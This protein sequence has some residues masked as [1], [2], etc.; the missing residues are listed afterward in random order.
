[1]D[2]IRRYFLSPKLKTAI[3]LD[4]NFSWATASPGDLSRNQP[5]S[6]M[7]IQTHS[8]STYPYLHT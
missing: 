6:F 1:M 5:R 4:S 2:F 8:F 3:F 7:H